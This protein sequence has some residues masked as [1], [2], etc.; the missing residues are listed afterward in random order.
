MAKRGSEN[1]GSMA[2]WRR[3]RETGGSKAG[4]AGRGIV[5]EAE[6]SVPQQSWLSLSEPRAT[7]LKVLSRPRDPEASGQVF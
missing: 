1:R 3:V 6:D 2:G 7:E 4:L 5:K